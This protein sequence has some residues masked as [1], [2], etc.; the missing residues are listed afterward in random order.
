MSD[1]KIPKLADALGQAVH[2]LT[3][4]ATDY[5]SLMDQI[6]DAR[7]VLIGE[8]SHGTHEF[9][10]QRAEITKRLIREKNFTAVAVE[11]DWT[12][13]WRVN[14]FVRA[15]TADA[16]A[17]EA[18]G[19][20]QQ[21]PLWMWRNVDVVNFVAWLRQYNDELLEQE[22]KVGFYGL[23]LYCMYA[24]IKAVLNYLQEVDPKAAQRARYRYSCLEHF[25][26]DAQAYGYAANFDLDKSCENAAVDQLVE[27]QRCTNYYAQPD[28]QTAEDAFFYA[29]QNA[30]LVKSAEKYYRLMFQGR[31]SSWNVRD[32]HMAETLDRLFTHLDRET[33]SA[34]IVVWEHNSHVGDAR[35]TESAQTGQ[36]TVGQ[37]VRER[38]GSNAVLIGLTTYT[39]TVAAASN[40]DAPMELKQVRPALPRSYEALF[41]Q[42]GLPQFLLNLHS[43][44]SAIAK[45][46][47]SRLERAIGVIYRPETEY[48]SH[49]F[50]ARLLDQFDAVIHLDATQAISPLDHTSLGEAEEAP[51]TFPSA[52]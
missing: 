32:R 39:G 14:R 25:D 5:D 3:G 13:A 6:G 8:A 12:N 24:S 20:F 46:R 49:Y 35:A 18:L 29:E 43:S 40:W 45:L 16:T 4:A 50:Y 26:E 37:L 48:R 11:A 47:Q 52:L 33:G 9:Y 38:Y 10:E 42:T 44:D 22:T 34:K 36:L 23:D 30:R 41:H 17:T 21:F 28:D 7:F 51:E 27:L 19:D 1:A 15:A 31:I 2:P